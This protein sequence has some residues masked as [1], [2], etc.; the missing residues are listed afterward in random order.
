MYW[1]TI[2]L[3]T[4]LALLPRFMYKVIWQIFWPSDIQIARE[5]EIFGDVHNNLGSKP[6]QDVS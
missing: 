5:A 6:E 2:L 3:I 4:V 1:L